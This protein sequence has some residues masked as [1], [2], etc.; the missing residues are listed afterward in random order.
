MSDRTP[1]AASPEDGP[2]E[3]RDDDGAIPP[4]SPARGVVDDTG[5]APEPSEPA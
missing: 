4:D 2:P 3:P 1:E 5:E